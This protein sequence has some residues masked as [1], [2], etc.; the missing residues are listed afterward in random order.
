VPANQYDVIVIG[1]GV[2]GLTAANAL[3]QAGMKTA[4]FEAQLFG[5]LIIN[6]NELDPAP[7]AREVGGAEFASELMQAN[8]ELGVASISEPVTGIEVSGATKRVV[9]AGGSHGARHVVIASGAR[10]RKLGVPGEAEFEGRGVSQCAD[11]DGPMYQNETVV[12]VGGGDSALQEAI[13]LT[14]YCG[15]VQLVHRG[16]QFR[17]RPHFIEQVKGNGKITTV[18]NARLEE[19]AGGKMVERARIRYA[20]GRSEEIPCAG[21]FA[22]V[23]L[24]PNVEFLPP[25]YARDAAGF[26]TTNDKLETSVSGVWAAGAVRSGCGGLISDAIGEAQRVAAAIRA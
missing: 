2:A 10:L 23:G 21:V 18:W 5:G 17:A 7:E 6:V 16:S 3:A 24:E 11:C 9:T 25:E 19:I 26:L 20:D 13:V 1:E 15:K 8:Q 14:H 22:Y 4:T 12:V